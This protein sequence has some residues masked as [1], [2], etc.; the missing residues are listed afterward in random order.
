[1]KK[2]LKIDNEGFFIEDVI[3]QSDEVVPSDCIEVECNERLYK[4]KWNGDKWVEGL[5]Q[6]EIDEINKSKPIIPTQEERI[7]ALEE[8]MIGV[9]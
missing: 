9:L 3:L 6:M 8:L 7:S 1:M 5:T 2:V 4:P